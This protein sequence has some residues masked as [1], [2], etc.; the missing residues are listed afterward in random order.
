[1]KTPLSQAYDFLL[2]ERKYQFH[3]EF[4]FQRTLS[5]AKNNAKIGMWIDLTKT[6]RYYDKNEVRFFFISL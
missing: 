5:D 4:V 2:P 1:M 6:S 3:P